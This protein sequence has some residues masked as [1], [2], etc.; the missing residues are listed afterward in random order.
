VNVDVTDRTLRTLMN[1]NEVNTVATRLLEAAHRWSLQGIVHGNME[2]ISHLLYNGIDQTISVCG[3]SDGQIVGLECKSKL[4]EGMD[5]DAHSIGA[6]LLSLV[7]RKHN[8]EEYLY[9]A[10]K[11]ETDKYITQA[12][13]AFNLQVEDEN[14][15]LHPDSLL[16]T[17][18]RGL[19]QGSMSVERCITVLQGF[20]VV[21]GP[22]IQ[23][24]PVHPRYFASVDRTSFPLEI[25]EKICINEKRERVTQ[26]GVYV[27]KKTP[28]GVPLGSYTGIPITA[29]YSVRLED[30]E[31][32]FHLISTS[33]AG[34]NGAC[35]YTLDGR[36]HAIF[37][38]YRAARTGQ[39]QFYNL[40]LWM[41]CST[42]N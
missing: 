15:K 41:K 32:H 5:K 9:N 1:I 33:K 13:S 14:K 36:N 18:I 19:I 26:H 29:A 12:I 6:L 20:N 31:K 40:S 37:D 23:S 27:T 30:C 2:D 42:C 16:V 21:S 8:G 7:A 4:K 22:R 28:S 11:G 35:R 39:V 34:G 38:L 25:R 3:W 17:V 24:F 10:I